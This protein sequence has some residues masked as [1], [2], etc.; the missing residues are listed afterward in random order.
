MSDASAAPVRSFLL[1]D[2]GE[3]LADAEIVAWLV[4]AGDPVA[5]D[6][7]VAEVETAKTAVQVPCPFGGTVAALHGAV[8]ETVAVGSP[9]LSV[10]TA[11]GAPD[12]APE[13]AAAAAAAGPGRGDGGAD[14]DTGAGGAGGPDG[15]GG[16]GGSGSVLVGS[17]TRAEG[18]SR[19]RRDAAGEVPRT[20]ASAA[21]PPRPAAVG[22]RSPVISPL[23]RRIAREHGIDAAALAGSGEG[24]L[25]LRRDVEA[26]VLAA[27]APANRLV[28]HARG[29]AVVGG[30]ADGG[31]APPQAGP[32]GEP[33]AAAER[34]ALSGPHR[35]MA[36]RMAR[37][38][39]EIPEATVWVD[40]DATG[41]LDLRTALNGADPE[42]PV[43]LLALL[44]R[45][46]VLGLARFPELNSRF[47]PERAELI[48]PAGV[49]LGFA[50]QT[51]RG[52]VVPVVHG[53]EGL[54]TR[55]LAARIAALTEQAR[56]GGLAP[57]Q[58]SGGTFTVNNYGVF[59]VDGAAAVINH[60]ESAIAG[61]G[62]II[63]RPWVL[64]AELAVRPVTELTLAFDHRVCDG[65]QAGG[66]LRL[67]ADYVERP[68]LLI[69]DT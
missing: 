69:G 58:L 37:S 56:A 19:R 18:P 10:R 1:P 59:G 28:P 35:A 16:A 4:Q 57:E 25:V 26:A 8:G 50:A 15:T 41:L 21:P 40:A 2:L 60:P 43:S 39:R 9:L 30:A 53:A 65:A 45:F 67:L 27:P 23:V 52:L 24:G 29:A 32:S 46:C 13:A 49:N 55:Q 66:F 33:P 48:R 68:S 47:D 63:N 62:R 36:Q 54:T 51:P 6:Q 31:T 17:G 11:D 61:M 7:P 22:N 5:V 34:I 12:P 64:G 44:A 42:R 3:G 20:M 14:G 38:R